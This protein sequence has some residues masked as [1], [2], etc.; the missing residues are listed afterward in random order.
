MDYFTE[1]RFGFD[2]LEPMRD[3]LQYFSDGITSFFHWAVL[4]SYK[5]NLGPHPR[6]GRTA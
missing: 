6:P 4:D 1:R 3:L 5:A 2:D